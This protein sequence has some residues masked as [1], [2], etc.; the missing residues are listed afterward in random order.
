MKVKQF[1]NS[2]HIGTSEIKE[3]RL[4]DVKTEVTGRLTEQMLKD[5]D[6]L[7]WG[8]RKI[9]GFTITDGRIIMFVE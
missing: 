5:M 3:V 9:N 7:D 6:Y 8:Q 2:Y 4:K 1:L